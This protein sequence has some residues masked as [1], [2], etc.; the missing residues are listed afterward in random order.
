M[1][2]IIAYAVIGVMGVALLGGLWVIVLGAV[3]L[4]WIVVKRIEL[5]WC[6]E[7]GVARVIDLW[8]TGTTVNQRPLMR[9]VLDVPQA[10]GETRRVRMTQLVD[11]G[12]MPRA[13]DLVPIL[14]DPKRPRFVLLRRS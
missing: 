1:N 14:V 12:W 7:N 9:I 8:Q 13:G 6:G 4:I 2:E 11:L 5:R 10:S 3:R